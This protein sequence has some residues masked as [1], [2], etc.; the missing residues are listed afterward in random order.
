MKSILIGIGICVL[1]FA[2]VALFVMHDF[3]GHSCNFGAY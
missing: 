1:G 2:A 3:C